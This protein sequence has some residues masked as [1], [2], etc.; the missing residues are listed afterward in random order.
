MDYNSKKDFYLSHC[1]HKYCLA[2]CSSLLW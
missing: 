2:F 1:L